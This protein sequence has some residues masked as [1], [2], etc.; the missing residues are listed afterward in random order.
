[1]G[2]PREGHFARLILG[3]C[4]LLHIHP[5]AFSS[6]WDKGPLK[7][8]VE[9]RDRYGNIRIYVRG[10]GTNI[11]QLLFCASVTRL[12]HLCSFLSYRP[13]LRTTMSIWHQEEDMALGLTRFA[14]VFG[15]VL[16]MA[17]I[18]LTITTGAGPPVAQRESTAP[19]AAKT[20]IYRPQLR[21][22]F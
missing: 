14:L 20:P 1:M 19:I 10:I 17:V 18:I 9:D 4:E 21:S 6:K 22:L 12:T 15:M 5:L 13:V 7:H 2:H 11:Q 16:A 3:L 8:L